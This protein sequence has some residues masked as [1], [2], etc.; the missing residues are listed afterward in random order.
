MFIKHRI[1]EEEEGEPQ[2]EEGETR[3]PCFTR[4]DNQCQDGE[5]NGRGQEYQLALTLFM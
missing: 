5:T 3:L 2:D 4:M 1:T